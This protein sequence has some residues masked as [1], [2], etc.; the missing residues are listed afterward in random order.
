MDV[1]SAKQ[2][3]NGG[4]LDTSASPH[5]SGVGYVIT[6]TGLC[7]GTLVGPRHV[8]TARHCFGPGAA[9][10]GGNVS[11]VLAAEAAPETPGGP[12]P[13]PVTGTPRYEHTSA[14]S[15]PVKVPGW[16]SDGH[17]AAF[18]DSS[19]TARDV[20][21]FKLDTAVP[22]YVAAFHP[23]GKVSAPECVFDATGT[24]TIVGYGPTAF[25]LNGEPAPN[26]G[27][28][29][30]A[31]SPGW[32]QS[33]AGDCTS[34]PDGPCAARWINDFFLLGEGYNVP[35]DSGGPLFVGGVGSAFDPPPVCGVCSGLGF[36]P[37]VELRALYA[38]VQRGETL[39]FIQRELAD[40]RF[41]CYGVPA[42]LDTDGD[43]VA[44]AEGCDNCP[45]VPNPDQAD[46]DNDGVGDACD[47][48]PAAPNRLQENHAQ[49][50]QLDEVGAPKL[51]GTVPPPP[52]SFAAT[53]LWQAL[54][55]GDACNPN[56]VTAL[57]TNLRGKTHSAPNPRTK[58]QHYRI[59]CPGAAIEEGDRDAPAEANN[60]L[61][62]QSFVGGAKQ[63]GNTR[64]AACDC[65]KEV[66]DGECLSL[67]CLRGAIET[68]PAA[69]VWLHADAVDIA[70]APPAT[71]PSHP[72]PT[73]SNLAFV[74]PSTHENA[75]LAA[76][77]LPDP[78]VRRPGN[79]ELGWRY[80]SDLL[81]LPPVAYNDDP[82][83]LVAKPL[84]W[85]WVRNFGETRP[86]YHTDESSPGA[87]KLRQDVS[88]LPLRELLRQNELTEICSTP[89]INTLPDR[90]VPIPRV[91][92]CYQCGFVG[93]FVKPKPEAD[94][95]VHYVAPHAGVLPL[96][97]LATP[98]AASVL[99]DPT[100]GIVT[101]TDKGVGVDGGADRA[102]VYNLGNHSVVG[103]L[104]RNTSDQLAFRDLEVSDSAVLA[105]PSPAVA[106]SAKRNEVA[107][108]DAPSEA[109]PSQLAMRTVDLTYGESRR[110]NLIGAASIVGTIVSA[111]YREQD[112]S[113]FLLTRGEDKVS[114][115][116]VYTNLAV[117][118]VL[119]FADAGTAT[120][121][122]LTV[123]DE[124]I[125]A[126]TSLRETSFAVV[127]LA[128]DANLAVSPVSHVS[129]TGP[130][131]MGALVTP[132]GLFLARAG[133]TTERVY[134]FEE[135]GEPFQDGV[136]YQALS[137]G[138]WTELFQ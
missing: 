74:L 92:P 69:W 33:T 98:K 35:G 66:E 48:C 45:T 68:A 13:G 40:V 110:Y 6:A 109:D 41:G 14:I 12:S 84:L 97:D 30:Y 108:F 2:A 119:D 27:V 123:S 137:S 128:V 81:N 42:A 64:M 28:R 26:R 7:T 87:R 24:G 124:G 73:Y 25:V 38:N 103:T 112:D 113:Y 3:V 57:T 51:G 83:V 136:S 75:A 79:R 55:P 11:F 61:L 104:F 21:I 116:R 125:L 47:N 89:F 78:L 32:T 29:N 19:D 82:N 22:S 114:L 132:E 23:V 71:V 65:P 107:F 56:P 46:G 101:A 80:W 16:F 58:P 111:A 135:Q 67:N 99:D 39:Q 37:L 36:A 60:V 4:T 85:S 50:A 105:S 106:M 34:D 138:A 5:F 95:I 18:D 9:A 96:A 44:D 91:T 102:V 77:F 1:G 130:V 72:N 10:L 90:V 93:T 76:T 31:S 88:R 59:T 121:A 20:A 115:Y 126:I 133:A 94:P 54:Y 53:A 118:L 100:L 17:D 120:A 129:G 117:Q 62:A 8:L 134:P 127:A 86:A 52:T 43:G 63:L 49:F 131:A 70:G 15:G 122:E